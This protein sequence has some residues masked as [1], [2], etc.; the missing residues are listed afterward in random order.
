MKRLMLM[1][2]CVTF[3][4]MQMLFAQGV[5]I[6][7]KVTDANGESMPGVTIQVKGTT[8][9]TVTQADGTYRLSVPADATTLIFS[10]VGMK[11]QEIEIAG[12]SII[13]VTLEEE[14]TALSEI[15]VVGYATQTKAPTP[16]DTV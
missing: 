7:G 1:L 15:V 4:G 2:L 9:G 5:T 6:T 8:S 3:A 12:Q 14:V 16:M 11:T 13:D 10:F